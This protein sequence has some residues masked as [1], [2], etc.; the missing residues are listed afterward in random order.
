M[1]YLAKNGAILT[2]SGDPIVAPTSGDSSVNNRSVQTVTP[3]ESQQI[4]S[5]SSP[6]TGLEGVIVQAIPSQYIIP[7]GTKSITSN[8]T[9]IDVTEYA[10]VDVAVPTGST[11]NNK[12][13]QTIVPTESQQTIGYSSPYTGL[14][15]V[16]VDAINSWYIGSN[17]PQ[18]NNSDVIIN[19]NNISGPSGGYWDEGFDISVPTMTLPTAASSSATSGYTS[20]ATISRSTSDQYINIPPGYN[21]AGGYYKISAVANGSVTAPATI[22]GTSATLSTGTGTLT[23]TKTVSVTPSVTTAGY[24]S[25]G[26]AGDSEI[27][28]TASVTINP[29][30]TANG[31]T[32]TIPA[33]Y[34]SSQATKSVST[35]TLPTA[36]STT[37]SGTSKATIGRSTSNQYINIPVGYNN[38]AAYYTISAVANGSATGPTS[39][40]QSSAT[41]STGTN[42]L[43]LTKQNVTTTPTVTAGYVSSATASTATVSLTAS[44]T[45]KAA[46]TYYPSTSDQTISASQYLT[47]AQTVKAV[48]VSGLDASKILSG[49]TVN[50]GD[51]ADADRITSVTGNVTF[52]TYYTGSGT[53]SSS[54]G[55]VGDIYLQTS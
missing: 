55:S 10:A 28:L 11:I 27:S 31:A 33:G 32:V 3:T 51:S 7:I 30:P 20:K 4:I 25:S 53:P 44:V 37:S 22:S 12:P 24:I 1:V 41:V 48:I 47:G 14:E 26:T 6:Y 46:A 9:D 13:S 40:T 49:T 15:E 18:Y 38:T 43:T 36:A 42:T 23:L 34:Y 8:G 52:K 54:L 39:I 17:I 45:T 19:G 29:T 5:Y 16:I 21:S 50:I 35:M 2:I